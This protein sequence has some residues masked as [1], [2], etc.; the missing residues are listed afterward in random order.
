MTSWLFFSQR[1]TSNTFVKAELPHSLVRGGVSPVPPRQWYKL[2]GFAFV[3]NFHGQIFLAHKHS[4]KQCWI[5]IFAV[6][7]V[8]W[9]SIQGHMK[10]KCKHYSSEDVWLQIRHPFIQ[11]LNVVGFISKLIS[12]VY[13]VSIFVNNIALLQL[14]WVCACTHKALSPHPVFD[15]LMCIHKHEEKNIW[16]KLKC[17]C[18]VWAWRKK[19]L[20]GHYL[21]RG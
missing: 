6:C 13:S 4:V 15:A 1:S 14:K 21:N 7:Y 12:S 16:Q 8:F 9:H 19:R 18:S 2:I 10:S 3:S 17:E 5:F 20:K 11:I